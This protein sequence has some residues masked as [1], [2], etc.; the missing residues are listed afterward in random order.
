MAF[1]TRAKFEK[2]LAE[3][4]TDSTYE[5]ASIDKAAYNLRLGKEVFLS[6]SDVPLILTDRHPYV[7]IQPGAY[8]LLTTCEYLTMPPDVL[9]FI[10]LRYK[11]KKRGLLNVSGFQVDP[12]FHGRL[13]FSVFNVGTHDVVLQLGEPMFMLFIASLTEPVTGNLKGAHYDQKGF[14]LEDII[15][16]QGRSASLV[17]MDSRIKHIETYVNIYGTIVIGALL[18][19]FALVVTL[20]LGK[21]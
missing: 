2:S 19:L 10:T 14:S 1:W 13:V 9:G 6:G 4:F 17:Q 5:K 15:A 20:V 21:H 11:Y 12:G 3:L 16:I 18:V 7:A 8:V